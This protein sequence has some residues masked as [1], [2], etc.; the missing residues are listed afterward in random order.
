MNKRYEYLVRATIL[1]VSVALAQGASAGLVLDRDAHAGTIVAYAGKP[2]GFVA[3]ELDG[4][5]NSPYADAL[6]R[7]IE[8]PLD[9]GSMFR[10]VRDAVLEST[11]G[12]QNPVTRLSLSG[13]SVYL[14]A[15]PASRPS[16]H[17]PEQGARPTR[18]ALTIGNADYEHAAALKTPVNDAAEVASALERLGFA[19]V[20]L[21]NTDRGTLESGFREFR[22][23]AA[24][25]KIAVVFY[26]GHG[27]EVAGEHFLVPVDAQFTST[28]NADDAAVPLDHVM[29]AV[30]PALVLRLIMLDAMFAERRK[31][32]AR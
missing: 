8:A 32:V 22:E 31:P 13:R 27:I 6:L 7:Y 11:S 17:K 29:H 4:A 3:D 24:N 14:A 23:M 21:E 18:V 10:W 30:E 15:N 9:V 12:R 28:D 1:M 5:R 16:G 20:R 2:G 25:A 19:V 26:S